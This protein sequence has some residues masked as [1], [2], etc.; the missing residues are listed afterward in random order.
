MKLTSNPKVKEV[1]ENPPIPEDADN[2][3][4]TKQSKT[5]VERLQYIQ[6]G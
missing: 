3:V 1:F 5:V 6:P 4:F 2:H